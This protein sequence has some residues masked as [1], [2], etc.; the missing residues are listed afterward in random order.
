[1]KQPTN[2]DRALRDFFFGGEGEGC[3]HGLCGKL[4]LVM[5]P[6]RLHQHLKIG[7]H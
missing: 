4:A 5:N 6:V 3:G 2:F 1:M 7:L